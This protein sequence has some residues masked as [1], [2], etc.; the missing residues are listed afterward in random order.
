MILWYQFYVNQFAQCKYFQKESFSSSIDSSKRTGII[1]EIKRFYCFWGVISPER[2]F[3]A[4]NS[5][6][7]ELFSKFKLM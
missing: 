6:I 5:A 2:K 1:L 7:L 4:Q 3:S